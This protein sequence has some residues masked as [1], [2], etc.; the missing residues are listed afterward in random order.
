MSL[1]KI[2]KKNIVQFH[3]G[4]NYNIVTVIARPK[5]YEIFIRKDD[6]ISLSE[7]QVCCRVKDFIM[8]TLDDVTSSALQSIRDSF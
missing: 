6:E 7:L 8:A 3:F 1:R 5:Y 2:L 4:E